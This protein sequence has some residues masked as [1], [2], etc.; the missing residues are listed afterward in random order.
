MGAFLFYFLF[1]LFVFS[2]KIFIESVESVLGSMNK[3]VG[4][5]CSI[6]FTLIP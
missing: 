5:I 3:E 4:Y 6:L 2:G 1:V